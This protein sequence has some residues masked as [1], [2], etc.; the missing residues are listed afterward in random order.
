MTVIRKATIN[1]KN[2]CEEL[3]RVEMEVSALLLCGEVD[4]LF[5]GGRNGV[6]SFVRWPDYF[7]D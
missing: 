5:I 2:R 6:L 7:H 1:S 3:A 4:V